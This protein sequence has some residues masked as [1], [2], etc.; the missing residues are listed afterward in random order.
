MRNVTCIARYA[1][2]RAP[3]DKSRSQCAPTPLS[4]HV[5]VSRSCGCRPSHSHSLARSALSDSIHE[6]A[7]LSSE[8]PNGQNFNDP[9]VSSRRPFLQTHAAH[10]MHPFDCFLRRPRGVRNRHRNVPTSRPGL[11][12]RFEFVFV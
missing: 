10:A 3:C 2:E 9:K 6:R 8:M 1:C 12:N 5:R 7:I 4:S 11:A